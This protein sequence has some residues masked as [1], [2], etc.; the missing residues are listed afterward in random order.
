MA[1]L[2]LAL[3]PGIDKQ[4]TEYGAEGG[5]TDC[6]Y[7]RFQYGLPE[8]VGG[9]VNFT[10]LPQYL[11]GMASQV[12]TWNSL[13]GIP[14]AIVGTNKKLY[15]YANSL[16]HDITPIREVD[17]TPTFTTTAGSTIL[18][19]NVAST[20]SIQVG[21]F[22]TLSGVTG[23]PGGITSADL[24]NQYEIQEVT[25]ST[26][27]TIISPVA[28]TTSQTAVGT[29]TATYEINTGTTLSYQSFGYGTGYWGASTWG[30]PRPPS[31]LTGKILNSR[32]W[33]FDT[34][35]E[36]VICQLVN[37]GTYEWVLSTG[38][39]VRATQIS[40]APTK[41]SFALVSTP[42][43]H[44]I[45]FGTEQ[46]IGSPATQ[47]PMFVRF[48][49][50]ENITDFEP[51]ATNTA[52][53][54]RITDGST[55]VTAIRSR[56]Q[57]LVFTDTALHGMQYI[58]PPYTFGF[59]QLGT[60][61]GCIGPHAAIDANGVA[62]WMSRDAFYVFDGTVKKIPCTVQDYVFKDLNVIQGYKTHVG[63][64]AQFNEV[65]WW[66]CSY[67]SDYIDRYVT[68]N[69]LENTWA[70]GTMPRS[71]W[72]D[73]GA[74]SRPV[75]SEYLPAST[76]TPISA[77]GN[78][79]IYGLTAGRSLIYSQETGT[80]AIDQPIFSYLKSGYFDIGDGD[81]MLFMKRFIPDF[82]NQ[83]GDMTVRLLLRAYPSTTPSPSSLDPYTVTPTTQK[84]DTRA[85]G[86]QISVSM[87]NNSLGGKWRFG[88]LR[89]D[90]QPDGLR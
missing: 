40:G 67:T 21:D 3:K 52:G 47:D 69:Y 16:W 56:G 73:T 7:V 1:L 39:S 9:W 45:C 89:V 57:T 6:D 64:N 41:S 12:F 5:W 86:R 76:E 63:I 60:N 49:D 54:Q 50:Q 14:Y 90:I 59:Q 66:Y 15:V 62:M 11:I 70:I 78:G 75:A 35:G 71:S 74:Y 48:S 25:S 8:K 58:G 43:R 17:T 77:T 28:A 55:I 20:L 30:T 81:N 87:E 53:G 29:M 18:T 65:T 26:T 10:P 27:Y 72:Q 61:C 37:G 24:N 44:L 34:Y 32:V 23:D 51:T 80:D 13:E 42:D 83:V 2:R 82:K 84:V 85:R 68:F 36:N 31:V 22:V 79:T 38:P 4:N 46:T 33:Q 19:I 88:T